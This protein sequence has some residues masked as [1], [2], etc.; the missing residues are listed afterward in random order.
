MMH[1]SVSACR[2]W[3]SASA[4]REGAGAASA[5]FGFSRAPSVRRFHHPRSVPWGSRSTRTTFFASGSC[6]YTKLTELALL[7]DNAALLFGNHHD[8]HVLTSEHPKDTSA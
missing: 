8:L 7:R 2:S 6:S 1:K 4:I 3:S 5:G